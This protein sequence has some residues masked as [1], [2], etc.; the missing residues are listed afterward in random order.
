MVFSC[1]FCKTFRNTFFY[2]THPVAA[3]AL[4]YSDSNKN[5][6][7]SLPKNGAINPA[8]NYMFK[9]NDRNTR[10]RFEICSKLKIKTPE[11][12]PASFWR[13]YC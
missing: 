1:E 5:D 13:L 4:Q 9:V 3:S 10:T 2:R 12:R 7:D 6:P 8:G 11:R